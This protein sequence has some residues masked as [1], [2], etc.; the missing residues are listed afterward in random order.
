[1]EPLRERHF[2]ERQ[3]L[4][5]R[6]MEQLLRDGVRPAGKEGREMKARRKP[7]GHDRRP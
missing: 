4:P 5:H 1:V 3:L 2:L 6:R 7:P